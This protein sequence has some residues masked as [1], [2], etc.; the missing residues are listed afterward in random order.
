MR[1]SAHCI[2]VSHEEMGADIAG[3]AKIAEMLLRLGCSLVGWMVVYTHCIW[4]GTLRV[5]GCGPDGDELWRLLL[6][7]VPFAVG[8]SFLLTSTARF[9]EVA[10]I[11]R[12]LAVPLVV[13][14]PLAAL[15]VFSAISSTTFASQPICGPSLAAWHAWWGPVQLFTLIVVGW[16]VFRAW[17]VTDIEPNQ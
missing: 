4:L 12:W 3:R 14:I 8:F 13:L 7:F 6:G 10:K 16:R 17:S 11:L 5:V 9:T 1:R 2:A 15:P